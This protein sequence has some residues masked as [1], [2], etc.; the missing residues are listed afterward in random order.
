[1]R[2]DFAENGFAFNS[3]IVNLLLQIEEFKGAW[4]GVENLP[5]DLPNLLSE[6]HDRNFFALQEQI[7]QSWQKK[8]MSEALIREMHAVLSTPNAR[9]AGHLST[10]KTENR[11]EEHGIFSATPEETP[12]LLAELVDGTNRQLTVH[13][14]PPLIII[15]VFV[16]NFLVVRPFA[17]NNLRLVRALVV[18]LLLRAGYSFIPYCK[19]DRLF[20]KAKTHDLY[21][22]HVAVKTPVADHSAWQLWITY[23]LR[24]LE[25]EVDRLKSE[26]ASD[27]LLLR[28]SP[29]SQRIVECLK[30][31]DTI[32]ITET[33]KLL[34]LNKYTLRGHFKR[35]CAAGYLAPVGNGRSRRYRLRYVGL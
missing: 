30:M 27:K 21:L 14:H 23:F 29:I 3:Q 32:S 7:C 16:A 10:Y 11:E 13:T 6:S 8:P 1:M 31:H 22:S 25:L 28:L 24:E 17:D 33:E 20:A 35:L 4:H 15:S 2:L 34:R 26:L 18:H 5:T 12:A 9:S 19:T